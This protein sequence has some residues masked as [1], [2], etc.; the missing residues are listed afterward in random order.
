MPMTLHQAASYSYDNFPNAVSI[1]F[2]AYAISCIYERDS[3]R[4]RDY[5][6]LLVTG[7]LLAPAKVVYVPIIFLVFM[8]AWKWK[9]TINK[10]AWILA[11][12]IFAASVAFA[13]LFFGASTADLAGDQLNWEGQPNYN[14]AFVLANPLQTLTIFLRTLYLLGPSYFLGMFGELLSG[15]TLHIPRWYI[16]IIIVL[17]FAS[18]LHG[19]RDE[20]QLTIKE[21]IILFVI[22]S[23][24]VFLNLFV[25]LL[26][27]T[28]VIHDVVIG[29]AGRY[30]IPILPLALLILRFNK[31]L[32][33]REAFRNVLI[34]AFLVM[35]S[36]VVMY[37]LNYT[38]GLYG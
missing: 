29:V 23:A 22:C 10:K 26:G 25:L 3:F 12:S 31:I 28:S 7:M 16:G 36:A 8:V 6:V 5:I 38:I 32:I 34:C 1:L 30:F 21:R 4:W 9:D 11:A 14:L 13:L 15:I 33:S 2:I 17:I 37:I 35:Q 20:W 24:V 19:K 27:W 18:V